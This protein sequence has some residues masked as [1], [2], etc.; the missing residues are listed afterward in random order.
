MAI[1]VDEF[2][3]AGLDITQPDTRIRDHELKHLHC[4]SSSRDHPPGRFQQPVNFTHCGDGASG[5][6]K[7]SRARLQKG[8]REL[9]PMDKTKLER[10]VNR[11]GNWL[12][13]YK[14]LTDRYGPDLIHALMHGGTTHYQTSYGQSTAYAPGHQHMTQAALLPHP[15]GSNGM[16]TIQ[17]HIKSFAGQS[18]VR[19]PPKKVGYLEQIF[20]VFRPSARAPAGKSRNYDR[21][22]I[23]HKERYLGADDIVPFTNSIHQW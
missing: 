12:P 7:Y 2:S 3:I 1:R 15:G 8:M 18:S 9:Y 5:K 14:D 23:T 10:V 11:R 16:N 20:A 21:G 17:Y 4:G 6:F 13:L 22:P 19:E